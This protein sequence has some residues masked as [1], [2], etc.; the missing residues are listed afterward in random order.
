M[1]ISTAPPITSPGAVPER[2][3]EDGQVVR[4]EEG[5]DRDRDDVIEHLPPGGDEADHL[6]E[7]VAGEARGPARLGVH[8][9]RLGVGGGGEHEDQPGDDE[10]DR[11][12][13][14]GEGGGHPERVVDRG[15]DVAVGGGEQGADAVH[16]AQR[17]VLRDP[18]SHRSCRKGRVIQTEYTRQRPRVRREPAGPRT[19]CLRPQLGGRAAT[20]ERQRQRQLVAQHLQHPPRARLAPAARPQSAGRPTSTASAPSASAIATSVPRRMPPSTITAPRP[21]TASTTSGRASAVA[22]TQ[23]SWRPPWLETTTPAAP[24]STASPASSRGQHALDQHRDRALRGE[25]LEVLPVQRRVDLGEDLGHE[26]GPAAEGGVEAGHADVGGHAEPGPPVALARTGD[27]A[28]RRSAGSPRTRNRPPRPSAPGDAPRRGSSRAG[29]SA[30]RPGRRPRPRSAGP[31]RS[32]TATSRSPP[33]PRRG[34]SP[35]RRPGR[36]AAGRRP[37]RRRPASRPGRRA[38]RCR[39]RLR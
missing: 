6:V 28:H 3:P 26:R 11:G 1:T 17:L 29:R 14:E 34:P 2:T 21:S 15:A 7:G 8:H 39:C 31:W 10:G 30:D 18:P 25:I 24:C 33:R 5:R 19:M 16:A 32:S 9:G 38:A 20:A 27:A 4:D 36:P 37:G 35:P 22:E 12:Q 13:P 23:S